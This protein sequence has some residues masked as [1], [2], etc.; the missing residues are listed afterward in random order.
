MVA[1][2]VFEPVPILAVKNKTC[3]GW[4]VCKHELQGE[5]SQDT[6]QEWMPSSAVCSRFMC[7]LGAGE[8]LPLG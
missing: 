5:N 7:S 3:R 6:G 8:D 4:F 2:S 1:F